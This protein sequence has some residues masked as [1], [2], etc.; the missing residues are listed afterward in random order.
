MAPS[1]GSAVASL[2]LRGWDLQGTTDPVLK[3][4]F[5]GAGSTCPACECSEGGTK[6]QFVP[7]ELGQ[8]SSA[9]DSNGSVRAGTGCSCLFPCSHCL[10]LPSAV[11]AEIYPT[12][13]QHE[14]NV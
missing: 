14:L 4:L 2:K 3:A 7:S 12:D 8:H 9:R 11:S 5:T 6:L 13:I 10:V 1:C